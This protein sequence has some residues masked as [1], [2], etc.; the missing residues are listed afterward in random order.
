MKT[1]HPWPGG[2]RWLVADSESP[3]RGDRAELLLESFDTE[4]EA[5]E[6]IETLPD[7]IDGRYSLYDM[8][9]LENKS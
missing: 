6:F 2:K 4:Q 9:L 3:D 8:S 5:A 1:N 7:Y